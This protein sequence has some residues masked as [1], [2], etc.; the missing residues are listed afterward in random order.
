MRDAATRFGPVA[1]RLMAPVALWLV[2]VALMVAA[3]IALGGL[4]R[5]TGSGL[6]MVEWNP[7][8]LLPP[9]TEAE[10][11][12]AFAK[13]RTSPEYRHVNAG[14]DL[15]GFKGIFWL[16][17]IH[18]LWG[19]LIGAVF[20]IPLVFFAARS[21]VDRQTA[22]RLGWLL[23]LGAA[24]GVLG[25][26]MV[27]SGLIDRPEVS[28]YRLAAHLVLAFVILGALLW[29]ALDVAGA[30]RESAP[31]PFYR[32]AWAVMALVLL[33]VTWGAFV[34]GLK[35]GLVYNTFPLMEGRLLPGD[36]LNVF[37]THGAVQFAH[38]VLAL[39]TV[40]ALTL[41]GLWAWRLKVAARLPFLLAALWSWVQAGLGIA[42]LILSVPIALAAIHQM[43]AVLLFSL[44][45]WGLHRVRSG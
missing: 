24:Q 4:T 25:W 27:A 33:T 10:W 9:L 3:M 34:A 6:S 2:A 39:M 17:Y 12:D 7:H 38:R 44:L 37:E 11:R 45:I 20:V 35:A 43:G 13:Y 41:L 22:R 15:D 19:R 30:F 26:L 32:A 36:G 16:E 14:M 40:A 8:H 1:P 5:L 31:E 23:V 28:H 21:M 42:T 18:R 29:T